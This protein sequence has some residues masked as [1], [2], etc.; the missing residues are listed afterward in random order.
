MLGSVLTR[1]HRAKISY[2]GGCDIGLRPIDLHLSG[3]KRPVSYTHLVL[4][5]SAPRQKYIRFRRICFERG[6]KISE[7]QNGE[8]KGFFDAR[9]HAGRSRAGRERQKGVYRRISRGRQDG[10][11]S[12]I[13]IWLFKSFSSW[14]IYPFVSS[15]RSASSS[16]VNPFWLRSCLIFPPNSNVALLLFF[17][18]REFGN[19]KLF[20]L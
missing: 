8:R 15:Q 10:H 14:E 16:C 18:A 1:F 20:S 5:Y 12:L 3:L 6:R 4:L 19:S 11:L 9:R 2:P 7:K 17:S 13:H